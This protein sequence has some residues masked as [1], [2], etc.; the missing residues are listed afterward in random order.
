M[1]VLQE[2]EGLENDHVAKETHH[3]P[4]FPKKDPNCQHQT[5]KNVKLDESEKHLQK[6]D[7]THN[8][9]NQD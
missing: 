8:Y 5:Y 1:E 2:L 9:P 7:Q 3:C 6:M 4:W